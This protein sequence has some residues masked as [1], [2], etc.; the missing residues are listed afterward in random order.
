MISVGNVSTCLWFE[1]DGLEAARFYTALIPNSAIRDEQKYDNLATGEQGGVLVIEFTLDGAPFQ[2]LQAG[3]HQEHNDM[4]SIVV[5]T[6]DQAETD[7]LWAALTADG[8][9]EVQC[10]W[11]KDRW[12]IAWQITPRR[13]GEL[14][15]NGSPEQVKAVMAAMMPMKRLDI[16]AL[17]RAYEGA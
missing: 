3:P 9:R 1:K 6:G 13:L 5:M 7:R 15:N 8:G 4:A 11:L 2:I 12:G 14:V 17:E 16:A 10:G